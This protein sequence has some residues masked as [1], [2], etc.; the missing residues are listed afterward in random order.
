MEKIIID[1]PI[2]Q[3]KMDYLNQNN[4]DIIGDY[5]DGI[6]KYKILSGDIMDL[7]NFLMKFGY[8]YDSDEMDYFYYPP[9]FF[10]R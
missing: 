2:N 10:G 6:Y 1:H 3:D 4:I 8:I 5:I 7:E 9:Q